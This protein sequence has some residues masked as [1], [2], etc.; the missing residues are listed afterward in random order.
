MLFLFDS[1]NMIMHRESAIF[2]GSD[3]ASLAFPAKEILKVCN[4][5]GT[6]TYKAGGDYTFDRK[7]N[8][9]RRTESSA[10]P[11]LTPE[12]LYPNETEAI[13]FPQKNANAIDGGPNGQLLLFDRRDFFANN[14]IEIDYIPISA[15]VW[16]LPFALDGRLSRFRYKLRQPGRE[17]VR[18]M[19]LG[20]SITDG[21][22]SSRKVGIAPFQEP[23]TELVRQELLRRYPVRL[24]FDNLAVSGHGSDAPL[25]DRS[26]W[27]NKKCDLLILAYGMNDF[28]CRPVAE[29]IGNYRKIMEI[30]RQNNPDVEF[31]LINPMT[32]NP[33]WELTKPGPDAL[34]SEALMRFC[35]SEPDTALADV[36]TCWQFLQEKKGFLSL[37]G[38]GVNHPNDYGHRVYASVVLELF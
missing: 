15:P 6:V 4:S 22:N 30:V 24:V 27:E 25:A 23:W 20:D 13:R 26:Y 32:G 28:S 16:P 12:K 2:A 10:I 17:E 19:L 33:E 3:T 1:E 35:A 9:L 5:S 21:W 37:T 11:M 29:F 8:R 14:Q 38:N 36:R 18:I 34:Y 31:L 7:T